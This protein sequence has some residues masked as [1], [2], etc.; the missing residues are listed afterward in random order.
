M[1]NYSYEEFLKDLNVFLKNEKIKDKESFEK[2]VK[3]GEIPF[4]D[5]TIS[6][7]N[8]LKNI[9]YKDIETFT[10]SINELKETDKPREKL[11]K[12]GPESLSEYELLAILIRSGSKKE[13]VL[14]LSKKLWIYMSKF[15]RISEIT[16]NDL[17]EIDGIGLS[18]ACSLISAL[19]LFK[20][21]NMREC[22]DNFSFCSPKSV[23]DIFMNILRDE[24]KE[25]FYVLLLDT[26]NKIISWN[27][28]SK[29]DL[30]SSIVHPREVFK[31]ALKYGANSIICLHNH[32]SGD[33]TPSSQDIDITKRLEDVGDLVG[34]RL[35]D[36]II[37][38]YNKY[39]SLKEKGLMR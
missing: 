24:M 15:H 5:K 33:P 14:T 36:H 38:G 9:E 25:H 26:K 17:M 1:S 34:I 8:R 32:P 20:R 6:E 30:N 29:G 16:I 27:E 28:I 39:I 35:L 18:K 2:E 22:V 3:E 11:Y 4:A 13:D 12:F 37:I 31:Y 19:E 21:L 7:V 23:A 10:I